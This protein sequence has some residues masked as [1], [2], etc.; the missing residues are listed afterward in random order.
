M[1]S[2]KV[3]RRTIEVSKL[4]K[5]LFPE[6]GYT[7]RDLIEYYAAVGDAMLPH[8]RDRLMTL[9]RF[10]DGIEAQ[11]FYSKD[12]PKY[13]PS[14]IDRKAVRKA[15][16]TVTHVVCNDKATLVYLANQAVI[17]PHV[18]L[19]KASDLDHP[20]QLMFDLDPSTDDFEVVRTMALAL[21]DFL[22]DLGLFSVVKTSGS[23]GLHLVCPLD[24]KTAS[25]DVREFARDAATV[26][27]SRHDDIAT[28]ETRKVERKGRLFVDWLRNQYAQHAVAPYGVRARP[29]APVAV[30]LAWEEVEDRKLR[31]QAWS[32]KAAVKRVEDEP[33]P[34]S[35]W[36]RRSRSLDRAR[37]R[38]DAEGD[39]SP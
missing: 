10:P 8:V 31:P 11:R 16:G 26:F 23:R 3:G 35:G 29:G 14:W 27:A 9:E 22:D 7:K 1:P 28:V 39:R 4:D 21:R 5:V 24:Q 2:M 34:W 25:K 20:D 12:V 17:T 15:G 38:L 33:D 18:S 30:P 36:R 37:S 19:Y 13:F 6:P 32:I